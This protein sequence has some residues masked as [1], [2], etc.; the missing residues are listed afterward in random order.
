MR[1][2]PDHT[3]FV[4]EKLGRMEQ[5]IGILNEELALVRRVLAMQRND[6]NNIASFQKEFSEKEQQIETL[7]EELAYYKNISRALQK[8]HSFRKGVI[9]RAAEGVCVCHEIP[10]S[11]YVRFTVWNARMLDITGYTLEEINIKGWYQTMYPNPGVQKK[12]VRRMRQMRTGNDLHGERW[13]VVRSDGEKRILSISTS[14]LKTEDGI[15]H[16]LGLMLDVTE[17]ERYRRQLET[18]LNELKTILDRA[19]S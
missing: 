1:I 19:I 3:A 2:K 6:H 17:E 10:E 15:T 11:P 12:A 5:Q 18:V 14:I 7:K 4:Q 16:V 9:E 13:E 8:D